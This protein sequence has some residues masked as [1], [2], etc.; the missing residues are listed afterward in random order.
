MEGIQPRIKDD[1]KCK[2]IEPY[3]AEEVRT[4]LFQMHP[5]K[6]PGINDFFAY[7]YQKFWGL[8]KENVCDEVQNI[9]NHDH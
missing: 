2:L 7:F 1:T 4:T 9:L 6:A 5:D 8:I 3:T